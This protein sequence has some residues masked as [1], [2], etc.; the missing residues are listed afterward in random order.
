GATGWSWAGRSLMAQTRSG[1]ILVVKCLRRG[2][3]P[4]LLHREAAWMQH[5]AGCAPRL[6]R[7]FRVPQPLEHRDGWL[8]RLRFISTIPGHGFAP[9][10]QE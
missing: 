8:V 4:A 5:L 1:P 9:R 2:E 6:Q 3:N 7:P 10:R